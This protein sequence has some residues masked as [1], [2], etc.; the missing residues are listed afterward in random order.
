[1]S[2]SLSRRAFSLVELLVVIAIMAVLIGLLLPAVQK[3]REAAARSRCSNNLKQVGL[4]LHNYHDANLKFPLAVQPA[5]NPDGTAT[6]PPWRPP[7]YY[8]QWWSWMAEMLAYVEGGNE[9]RVADS[10]ARTNNAWPWGNGIVPSG[11]PG[12]LGVANPIL[13][14]YMSVYSCPTDP[15]K[16]VDNNPAV[17][18][19]NGDIAFTMYLGVCGRKGG[20]KPGDYPTVPGAPSRDGVLV[21]PGKLIAPDKV[22]M[23]DITDGTSNTLMVGERPPSQDLVW[24][25]WFAGAGW[26]GHYFGGR[27]YYNGIRYMY[28][29]TLDVTMSAR[30]AADADFVYTYAGTE[31]RCGPNLAKYLGLKPGDIIDPCHQMHFWSFHSGGANFVRADGSVVFLNYSIDP[32]IGDKDLFV[33]LCTRNGGESVTFP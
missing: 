30:E 24:G 22:Q 7:A 14:K 6:G 17:T 12:P 3:V 21:A 28:G 8:H 31:A 1:M 9:F 20:S 4:A 33:A 25:W 2:P 13:G 15:R 29:G 23:T 10:W 16:P 11:A 32:G 5:Y 27:G 18:G 26:E 19:V